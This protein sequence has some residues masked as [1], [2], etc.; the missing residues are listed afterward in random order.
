MA[1]S[2][3]LPVGNCRNEQL[4]GALSR[5]RTVA[6]F[7]FRVFYSGP[8]PTGYAV[9]RLPQL[10]LQQPHTH[11]GGWF[12]LGIK[13]LRTPGCKDMPAPVQGQENTGTAK[14]RRA[15]S[16]IAAQNVWST[17]SHLSGINPPA[18]SKLNRELRRLC[19]EAVEA[20]G[21]TRRKDT[22]EQCHIPGSGGRTL[23]AR[24]G[25]CETPV[26]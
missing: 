21:Q 5:P 25:L 9:R 12:R 7:P 18:L 19:Y 8:L 11:V 15:F 1:V 26:N 14:P 13:V 22:F 2:P 24:S 10:A 20:D 16:K 6:V 4:P 23:S 3:G 17:L